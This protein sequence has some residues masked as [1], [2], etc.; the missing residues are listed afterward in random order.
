MPGGAEAAYA[1]FQAPDFADDS[2]YRADAPPPP[3]TTVERASSPGT[4]AGAGPRGGAGAGGPGSSEET[5]VDL[6]EVCGRLFKICDWTGATA[7]QTEAREP[8]LAAMVEHFAEVFFSPPLGDADPQRE[9]LAMTRP[10]PGCPTGGSFLH[11]LCDFPEG[12]PYADNF[13]QGER[14]LR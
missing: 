2:P 10:Y 3:G 6:G 1:A 11:L 8:N 9:V 14:K 4:E 5:P 13:A 7:S 12:S